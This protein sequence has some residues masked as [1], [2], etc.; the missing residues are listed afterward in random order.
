M[1]FVVILTVELSV[2][3]A[4][5]QLSKVGEEGIPRAGKMCHNLNFSDECVRTNCAIQL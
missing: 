1:G 4:A 3:A 2:G 5:E